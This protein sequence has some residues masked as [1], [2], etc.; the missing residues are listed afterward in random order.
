MYNITMNEVESVVGRK[1][2][3]VHFTYA[4]DLT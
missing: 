4:C 3:E 2:K 1:K